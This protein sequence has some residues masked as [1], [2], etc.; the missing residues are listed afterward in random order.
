MKEWIFRLQGNKVEWAGAN[1][2]LYVVTK[3]E[4]TLKKLQKYADNKKNIA[5]EEGT[6]IQIPADKM[7]IGYTSSYKDFTLHSFILNKGDEVFLFSDGFADQFGGKLNKKLKLKN[8]KRLLLRLYSFP[9]HFQW[10]KLEEFFKTWKGNNERTDDIT[11]VGV[12][13]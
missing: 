5:T 3:N 12:R 8:F 4:D 11:V 9:I 10:Q 1:N 2:P 7:P 13:I 6:L